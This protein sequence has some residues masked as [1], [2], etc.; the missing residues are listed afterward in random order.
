MPV[1]VAES[2]LS[3]NTASSGLVGFSDVGLAT[4]GKVRTVVLCRRGISNF[5]AE[6]ASSCCFTCGTPQ[7]NTSTE[8]RIHGTHARRTSAV[9]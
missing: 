9:F 7:M 3:L 8:S 4:T 6:R 2:Q 5:G 1:P